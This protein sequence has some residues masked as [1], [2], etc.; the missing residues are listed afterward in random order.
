MCPACRGKPIQARCCPK[1]FCTSVRRTLCQP[2]GTSQTPAAK[3]PTCAMPLERTQERR[4]SSPPLILRCRWGKGL[5]PQLLSTST[6][7]VTV[8]KFGSVGERWGG[9]GVL[10]STVVDLN[11]EGDCEET[12]LCRRNVVVGAVLP[13]TVADLNTEGDCEE[14]WQCRSLVLLSD[15]LCGWMFLSVEGF[16]NAAF[17]QMCTAQGR[18]TYKWGGDSSVVRAPDS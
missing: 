15:G 5:C 16:H 10:P 12:R 17:Q 3:L 4:T 2:S 1:R 13:S 11:A 8:R 18:L 9:V 14:T 7:K 6:Q